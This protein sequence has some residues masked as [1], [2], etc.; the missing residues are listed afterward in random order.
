MMKEWLK[1]CKPKLSF[2]CLQNMIQS[3]KFELNSRYLLS[4]LLLNPLELIQIRHSPISFSIAYKIC[5]TLNIPMNDN[6]F[7][8]KWAISTV[9]DNNGSF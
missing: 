8:D 5:D 1:D 2:G 3:L 4:N 9:Q 6:V 7:V